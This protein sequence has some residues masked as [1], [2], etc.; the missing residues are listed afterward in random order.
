M[1]A[2]WKAIVAL[3]VA[4]LLTAL[5]PAQEKDNTKSRFGGFGV[6]RLLANE[7]VQKEL[8]LSNDDLDKANTAV[9]KVIGKFRN[10]S[11]KLSNA[12]TEEKAAFRQKVSNEC[13]KALGDIL[14]PEQ[15]KRLKQIE[16][17]QMGLRDEATQSALK[18]TSEQKEKV[19]QIYEEML[20]KKGQ[21]LTGVQSGDLK[22][23]SR[24]WHDKE[25]AVLTDEQKKQWK[26]MTGEPFQI[27]F[28]FRRPGKSDT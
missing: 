22:V 11:P 10:D 19:K 20:H 18:L 9:E 17:Q 26:D 8:K 7:S 27:K 21:I 6:A 5:A 13:F 25:V 15:V 24:E 28:E 12:T 14:K 23:L 4:L 2:L 1:R 16:L 3:S